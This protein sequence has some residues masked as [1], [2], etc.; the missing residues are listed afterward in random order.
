MTRRLAR[1]A[2]LLALVTAV[3]LGAARPPEG[4]S[5]KLPILT[6]DALAPID[7]IVADEIRRGHVPGAVVVIGQQ[8]TTAYRRA[9]GLR[10]MYSVPRA[11]TDDTIFDLAS[12]TKV[13]ATTTAVLQLAER[14]RLS[15]ESPASVYWPAFASA[16]KGA[17]TI[18]DL[19]THYS[20]RRAGV[21]PT[22]RW[23]GYAAAMRLVAATRPAKPRG[24]EYL[25]SDQNFLVLGEVVRRVSGLPLD[26]Y[27]ERHIFAP[28][29]MSATHFR[30]PR[31]D[32]RRV[33]PTVAGRHA[34][35]LGLV[36]DPTARRM[37]GVAGHAGLFST[38]ADLET[39]ARML[40]ARGELTGTRILSQESVAQMSAPQSPFDAAR[41]RGFG[42]DL[43]APLASNREERAPVGSYG[44]TGY[45]GTMMWIDPAA[46]VYVI[47]L[48]NRTYA[49]G[50]G[51]AQPLRD[52]I[53]ELV[54]V[55][56]GGRPMTP[57]AFR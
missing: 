50:P 42:W 53:L 52:R 22:S 3:P 18:R 39:F 28:L 27:C 47:V 51:D 41:H 23:S 20:G 35:R 21:D 43:A 29:G 2:L 9:F 55:S 13:I 37:G 31:A 30:V 48:S 5:T 49:D 32:A 54:T 7:A 8:D 14:G 6:A 56:L 24:T 15:I 16:G 34:D 33:A 4:V 19:L 1:V 38:A 25:Y 10:A 44:H 46:Q 36:H 57:A 40:L 17:I 26:E 12:L 45:T 11:M